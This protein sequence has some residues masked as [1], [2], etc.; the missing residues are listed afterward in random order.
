MAQNSGLTKTDLGNG[1][2]RINDTINGTS[3]TW[4]KKEWDSPGGKPD[5]PSGKKGKR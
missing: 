5:K 2:L 1:K 4:D 3:E